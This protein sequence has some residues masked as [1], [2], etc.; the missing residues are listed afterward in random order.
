MGKLSALYCLVMLHITWMCKQK[1]CKATAGYSVLIILFTYNYKLA[2][3][4]ICPLAHS[5]DYD[6]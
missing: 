3:W 4:H 1:K 2:D 5:T 6:I